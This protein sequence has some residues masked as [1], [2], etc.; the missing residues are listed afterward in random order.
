[1]PR[2]VD[3]SQRRAELTD[4]TARE[5]ARVGLDGVRVRDVARAAGSTSGLLTYYFTDKRE[6][7]L[8]TFRDRTEHARRRIADALTHGRGELDAM[9]D[10]LLPIDDDGVLTWKVWLA[11][12][13]AAVG[14]DV[15]ADEQR[16]RYEVFTTGLVHALGAEAAA[17]RL[18]PG[19]DLV[20]EARRLATV[21]DGIAVQALFAPAV[22]PA[23]TQRRVVDE[24]LATLSPDP[25][26]PRT[27]RRSPRK[28]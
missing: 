14:D 20:H 4:A 5:I 22:W 7:L 18:R 24:H 16:H 26:R 23:A 13:G 17:G 19:L 1:M 25:G 27:P 9:V 2:L 28:D 3:H 15:L 12:W 21:I 8:A 10:V 11:F 6:L